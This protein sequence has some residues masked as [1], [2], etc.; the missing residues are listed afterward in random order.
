MRFVVLVLAA[1]LA[2]TGARAQDS[3]PPYLRGSQAYVPSYPVYFRWAGLYFGGHAGYT[4]GGVDVGTGTKSL[5]QFLLRDTTLEREACVSC[6]VTLTSRTLASG[7]YGGF[8]GYNSQWDDIVLGLEVNYSRVASTVANTG[9]IER[10]VTLSD[11]FRYDVTVNSTVQV[12]L[13][14][15]ATFRARAGY[16]MGPFLPWISINAAAGRG[17]F[18]KAASV[19][20]PAPVDVSGAGRT[21]PAAAVSGD[22]SKN[23]VLFYGYGMA[24]GVDIALLQN[25]F[26]RGE[27]EFTTMHSNDITFNLSTVRAGLGFKF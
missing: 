18:I 27:Y 15:M 9:T 7:S 13:N 16:V 12:T 26:V 6:F 11:N 8:M 4:A 19:S 1:I 14:D 23:D 20:Y 3:S 24:I 10:L 5:L 21:L 25:V 22:E 2:A 17:S